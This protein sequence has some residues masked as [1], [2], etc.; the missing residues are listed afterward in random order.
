MILA[1]LP[2]M[3]R[4]LHQ[5][6]GIAVWLTLFAAAYLARRAAT[7]SRTVASLT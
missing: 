5:A 4:S 6:I 7:A 1:T 3:L 2:P